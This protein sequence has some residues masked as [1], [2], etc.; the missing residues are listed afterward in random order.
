MEENR[1]VQYEN[2]NEFLT[3]EKKNIRKKMIQI[4]KKQKTASL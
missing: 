4:L 1:N 3:G 2:E